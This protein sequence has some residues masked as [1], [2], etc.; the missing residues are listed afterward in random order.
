MF[1]GIVAGSFPCL[2]FQSSSKVT[3]K[4][5]NSFKNLS[6][7]DSVSV[8]GACLTV[9][10]LKQ[11]KMTF[12]L[13]PETLKVTQWN[14]DSF[15]NKKFN[16]ENSL[17]LNQS[18]GGHLVTGHVDGLMKIL[19]YKK[20]QDS[21]IITLEIPQD[22]IKFFWPKAYVTLNGVSLTVNSITKNNL[23]V[24]VIPKTLEISNLSDLNLG[25]F[26]LFEVDYLARIQFHLP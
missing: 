13:G 11:D 26:C 22:Y 1:S 2:D 20:E 6:I 8:N 5:P 18:L 21:C 9:E 14:S 25:D 24:C 7:G 17:T 10:D 3:F 15:K 16:L 19:N 12:A 4:K 23:E